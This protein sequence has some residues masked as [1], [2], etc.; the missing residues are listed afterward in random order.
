MTLKVIGTGFGRTGTDSMRVALAM[1]GFGPCHHMYEINDNEEQRR[2]WRA[3]AKGAKPDW[4]RLFEGY[5]SCVDWPSAFYW[6][7][8]IQVYPDAKVLLTYR[9]P[10]SWWKSFEDILLAIKG[11]GEPDPDSLG[12]TLV[13]EQVFG[14]RP[15]DKA[16]AMAVYRA[17]VED[18]LATVPPGRLLVHRLGD[19]WPMLCAHLGVPQPNE[20]YPFRNTT[21]DMRQYLLRRSA[22][23]RS[24]LQSQ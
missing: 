15:D 4:E 18:V 21:E 9:A 22:G 1:L 5:A 12:R 20:P 23:T 3:V 17:N 8:L 6:R 11:M 7:E 24:N 16:H 14:G 10:E 13:A 2:L 19:G